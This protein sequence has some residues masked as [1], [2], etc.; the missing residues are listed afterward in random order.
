MLDI[1]LAKS[2]ME[3]EE[4]MNHLWIHIHSLSSQT[5]RHAQITIHLP[6]GVCRLENLNGYFE[7]G[8]TSILL[9]S[10]S[11]E[12]DI[13]IEI[14]TQQEVACGKTDISVNLS[15]TDAQNQKKELTSSIP[16]YLVSENE[17]DDVKIDKEVISQLEK[18]N[19]ENAGEGLIRLPFQTQYLTN[20]LSSLERKYRIDC[21]L[22]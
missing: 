2:K 3:N 12:L 4:G 16:L 15:Y 14:Y 21:I 8:D 6:N 10:I 20:E 22:Y 1:R 5:P 19:K 9:G 13:M 11:H 18:L 7:D 17:M